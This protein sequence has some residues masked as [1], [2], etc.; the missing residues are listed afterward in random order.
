MR[1]SAKSITN[2]ANIN[3]FSYTNQWIIRS[4]EPNTL[5]F[6]LVD[7]DQGPFYSINGPIF[8]NSPPISGDAGLRY[9]PGVGVSNQPAAVM[10]TFPSIDDSKV[11][12]VQ[13]TLAD[14]LDG[15]IWKVSL[16]ASQVPAGGN[17]L[18]AVSEGS[19][20]RRFSATNLLNVEDP[21]NNG[22]C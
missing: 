12:T 18:F 4:G 8:G 11:I 6:Q 20:T 5:Y 9:I 21:T 3:N 17:V 14:A 10:V 15:S 1:L 19:A 13:A 7:L 2:Y 22:S 16:G